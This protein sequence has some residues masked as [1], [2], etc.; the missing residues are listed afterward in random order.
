MLF[1]PNEG[2]PTSPIKPTNRDQNEAQK[3]EG[4]P[5]PLPR[6]RGQQSDSGSISSSPTKSPGVESKLNVS[7]AFVI[8]N[9]LSAEKLIFNDV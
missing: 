9:L 4:R 3:G 7:L 2:D 8:W 1:E 6:R 5:I